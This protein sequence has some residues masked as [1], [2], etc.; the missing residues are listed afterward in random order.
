MTLT[1]D[2]LKSL[3][4][5]DLRTR[6]LIP[7]FRAMGLRDVVHYHG[8][9][10][11]EG[12]DIVM[13]EPDRFG[14]RKNV[15]VVAK[16]DR[17]SGRAT[18][19]D[20]ASEVAFQ[21]QQCFGSPFL[22]AAGVE[23]AVNECWVVSS[24]PITKEAGDAIFGAL[25]AARLDRLVTLIDGDKLWALV[26]EHLPAA[27]V[28][29]RL[30]EAAD[31]FETASPNYRIAALVDG[32]QVTLTAKPKHPDA[33]DAEPL[34]F[35]GTFRFDDSP[36]A[37][38]ARAAFEQHIRTGAPVTIPAA[39]VAEFEMPDFVRRFL[40]PGDASPTIA[41]GPRTFGDRTMM[42]RLTVRT[43]VDDRA[44]LDSL[45]FQVM[46]IGTEEV[47][48]RHQEPSSPWLIT[49]RVNHV[50]RRFDMTFQIDYRGFTAT[51]V[52]SCE[53]FRHLLSQGGILQL[54]DVPSGLFLGSA[55]VP[56]GTV[57]GPTPEWLAALKRLAYVQARS[58]VGIVIP[59]GELAEDEIRAVHAVAER[60]ET[61]RAT[62]QG[63]ATLCLRVSDASI[64]ANVIRSFENGGERP[65]HFETQQTVH[66]FD[67]AIPLG[68]VRVT[69][70]AATLSAEEAERL[71]TALASSALPHFVTFAIPE[72]GVVT[73]NYVNVPHATD[74]PAPR[75]NDTSD[76]GD[77]GVG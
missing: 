72:T 70:S 56:V 21:I 41:L 15:A 62:V 20:S 71:R 11:E 67:A 29:D 16:A 68:P 73:Y 59:Q 63:P 44:A 64:A 40:A 13:W 31:A 36:A 34:A 8:G 52:Y 53:R 51:H 30:R 66:L 48:V 3:S 1:R 12:K 5:A 17:V 7:L 19:R 49:L 9:V 39:H 22:D 4:E 14:N 2:A 75:I 33:F 25:R 35:R 18:G 61:G 37:E 23:Q 42:G 55:E 27:A 46:Q 6:V 74:A 43:S 28:L 57:P 60:I 50:E 26:E 65:L 24:H 47:T 45:R 69:V 32:E 10:K 77:P 58:G 38:A 54:E 76:A